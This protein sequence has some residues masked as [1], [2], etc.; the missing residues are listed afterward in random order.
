MCVDKPQ[1]PS[2][3]E[4]VRKVRRMFRIRR[5]GHAGT[6]DPQATGLLVCALG[7]ATRLLPFLPLEPKHYEFT[8]VFGVL[9]DT[10]DKEGTVV[11]SGEPIPEEPRIREVLPQFIGEIQ[12]EPP[13]YSSIKVNGARAYALARKNVEFEMKK[14]AIRVLSLEMTSFDPEEG[15]GAFTVQC[16][17]GT[18]VRSLARDI[19]VSLG[20]VGYAGMVR[21]VAAGSFSLDD[22]VGA[23]ELEGEGKVKVMS[24]RQ[25]FSSFP[26]VT[27]T[28]PQQ[29][30][31][32]N[33][34]ALPLSITGESPRVFAYDTEG[35]ILAVLEPT[36]QGLHRP[37]K[38]FVRESGRV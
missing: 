4:I 18:Y 16:S 35:E 23:E 1:G 27:L 28:S 3:F 11:Q 20:T 25:A 26:S 37:V 15:V 32:K 19:A 5:V 31:V 36:D 29:A 10:L 22:A 38:V 13:R 30:K 21:R 2:S 12:Q 6:L 34:G 7:K 8:V 24:V 17:S 14:R 33:G 9:T